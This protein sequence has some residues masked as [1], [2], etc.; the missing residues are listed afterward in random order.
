[1]PF[2]ALYSL[3]QV[4]TEQQKQGISK[5]VLLFLTQFTLIPMI[6]LWTNTSVTAIAKSCLACRIAGAW[7]FQTGILKFEE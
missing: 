4:N 7:A 6:S 1:V 2:E 3:F 5:T